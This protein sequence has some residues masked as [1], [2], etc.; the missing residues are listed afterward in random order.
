MKPSRRLLIQLAEL[1]DSKKARALADLLSGE[2]FTFTG[3]LEVLVPPFCHFNI[4]K[5]AVNIIIRITITP[6]RIIKVLFLS[7]IIAEG[8][9]PTAEIL[10][11]KIE[12]GL[13][14]MKRCH[15]II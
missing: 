7:L 15:F 3:S 12:E 4:R 9:S 13:K 6:L 14:Q 8:S 5:Y 1:L 2:A 11:P 10:C